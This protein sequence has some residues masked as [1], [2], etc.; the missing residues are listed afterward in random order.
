MLKLEVNVSKFKVSRKAY[1]QHYRE[2]LRSNAIGSLEA[3]AKAALQNIPLWYGESR[4]ALRARVDLD[5]N[6]LTDVL[7]SS[8]PPDSP[9][10]M[11]LTTRDER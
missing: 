1:L 10:S 11:A 2:L 6:E 8:I 9:S 3:F 4:G 5:G 7:L